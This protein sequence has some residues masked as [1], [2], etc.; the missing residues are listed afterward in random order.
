MSDYPEPTGNQYVTAFFDS[1]SDADAAIER[2]VAEGVS[3]NDIRVVDG[4]DDTTTADKHEDKGFFEMLGDLFMPDEDRATYAE[5]LHRGGYLVSLTVMAHNRDRVLDILD[6]EGTVDMD[7]REQSWRSEGWTGDQYN[8]G[9][10][11][12]AT[13]MP[14][15]PNVVDGTIEIIEEQIR[16]GKREVDHGRVRVRS[17]VVETPVEEQVSL[18]DERVSVERRVVDREVTAGDAAFA[19]HTLEATETAEE[20]VVSKQA[21]VVE[22]ITLNKDST[23]H[24]ETVRDTVRHT[25]VEIEDERLDKSTDR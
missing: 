13:T 12:A 24:T 20:A 23:E 19:E 4:R 1:R 22:E 6:D 14:R 15:E 2:I 11:P 5:G 17:Y 9:A 18:H 3:R 25:E 21:R 16:I 8:D 10:A 7:A